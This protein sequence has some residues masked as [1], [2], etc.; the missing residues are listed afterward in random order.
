MAVSQDVMAVCEA[1]QDTTMMIALNSAVA[2][3]DLQGLEFCRAIEASTE[4]V[5]QLWGRG[6]QPDPFC[7]YSERAYG[8]LDVSVSK[9]STSM[10]VRRREHE[11]FNH[12]A[13]NPLVQNGEI[14][15]ERKFAELPVGF[16]DSAAIQDILKQ[17]VSWQHPN[18]N[19]HETCGRR[20]RIRSSSHLFFVRSLR[21]RSR[22]VSGCLEWQRNPQTPLAILQTS[23]LREFRHSAPKGLWRP[24]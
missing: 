12:G 20:S 5:E 3:E 24:A 23:S 11:A 15:A 14:P 13:T 10:V 1:C 7:K 18:R 19:G 17:S 8:T 16:E 22:T 21:P 2:S 9:D 6:V 4:G